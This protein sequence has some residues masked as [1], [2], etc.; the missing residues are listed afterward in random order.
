MTKQQRE[1]EESKAFIAT[2]RADIDRMR[3]QIFELRTQLAERERLPGV[4]VRFGDGRLV[5]VTGTLDGEPCVFIDP[6]ENPGEVGQ[7]A[8]REKKI[9]GT[10]NSLCLLFPAEDQAK[11]VADALVNDKSQLAERDAALQTK[12]KELDDLGFE[13]ADLKQWQRESKKHE[14]RKIYDIIK[15]KN[16]ENGKIAKLLFDQHQELEELRQWQR[17][18]IHIMFNAMPHYKLPSDMQPEW[19]QQ[20]VELLSEVEGDD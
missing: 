20:K 5:V 12:Q 4:G 15:E 19:M 9:K 10:E 11:L 3:I 1:L 18:A 13:Y 14:T 6:A 16:A 8:D 7:S 2:L 17:K